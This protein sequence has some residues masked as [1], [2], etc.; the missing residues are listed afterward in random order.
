MTK[1][2]VF[3][4]GGVLIPEKGDYIAENI[5]D[6][7]GV[8]LEH[9]HESLK[10]IRDKTTTGEIT[11]LEMYRLLI[12]K[13]GKDNDAK[14]LYDK[15]FELYEQSSTAIDPQIVELIRRLKKNYKVVSLTNTEKEIAK[16]NQDRGLF[17]I[18]EKSYISCDIGLKKPGEEIY[19]RMLDDLGVDSENTLFIDNDRS[20]VNGAEKVGIPSLLFTGY[21]NLMKELK[22]NEVNLS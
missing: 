17:D 8:S 4:L 16:F 15:H 13:L 12:E 1:V 11:L 2:I 18:F 7:L 3:D 22:L 6:I 14:I 9:Y 21:R 5:S 10:G 20:Y 19:R